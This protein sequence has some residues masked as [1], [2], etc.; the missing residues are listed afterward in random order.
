MATDSPSAEAVLVQLK[1]VTGE[2][3]RVMVKELG[4]R[5][6]SLDFPGLP[7]MVRSTAL[8]ALGSVGM[9]MP[10]VVATAPLAP[11]EGL[12]PRVPVKNGSRSPRVVVPVT[13]RVWA[14]TV[15][16]RLWWR[17]RRDDVAELEVGACRWNR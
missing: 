6:R 16:F 1:G 5:T 4:S 10:G 3:A 7:L 12:M 15:H 2:P 17:V 9:V 13:V 14:L 8:V 11:A